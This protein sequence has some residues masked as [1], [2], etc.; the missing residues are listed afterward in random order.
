M[1]AIIDRKEINKW[2]NYFEKYAFELCHAEWYI[3]SH[4]TAKYNLLWL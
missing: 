2:V 3:M 1:K 4:T